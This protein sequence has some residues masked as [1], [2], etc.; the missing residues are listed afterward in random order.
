MTKTGA[1]HHPVAMLCPLQTRANKVRHREGIHRSKDERGHLLQASFQ[2]TMIKY[3]V[4]Y[5]L[6]AVTTSQI[7]FESVGQH[8]L[9][10]RN[11]NEGRRTTHSSH[12]RPEHW[13][14]VCGINGKMVCNGHS[15]PTESVL[16]QR[17]HEGPQYHTTLP[18]FKA[19][20]MMNF[21]PTNH[22]RQ[23]L[24]QHSSNDDWLKAKQQCESGMR[25]IDSWNLRNLP[26]LR[27]VTRLLQYWLAR[28]FAQTAPTAFQSVHSCLSSSAHPPSTTFLSKLATEGQR[29]HLHRWSS[30]LQT[31]AHGH[32]PQK[33]PF[34][35]SSSDAL[36]HPHL[37]DFCGNP[38]RVTQ[39]IPNASADHGQSDDCLGNAT[40]SHNVRVWAHTH[41]SATPD[42]ENGLAHW[43]RLMILSR[44]TCQAR[45]PRTLSS[46]GK[47]SWT[48]F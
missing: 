7:F 13:Q 1:W 36:V 3:W 22:A 30:P 29:H 43:Q 38:A 31:D 45:L 28:R 48:E 19:V 10:T 21:S 40:T 23:I 46:C 32:V 25:Q 6:A 4:L 39:V 26:K 24:G 17:A 14:L 16:L 8:M 18:N 41:S 33:D 34:W 35:S 5:Q 2:Q 42:N 9:P 44:R 37:M 20:R 27:Q 11:C 12:D 15:N 47:S